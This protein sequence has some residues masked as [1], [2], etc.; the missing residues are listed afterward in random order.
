MP[1]TSRKTYFY[2]VHP[3]KCVK[4]T[5]YEDNG[6]LYLDVEQILPVQDVGD[7][8]IR[9]NAKKQDEFVSQKDEAARH[10]VRREFWEFA[11]PTLREKTGIYNNV[12]PSKN[13]SITGGSG[14]SG[15]SYITVILINGARAELYIDVG[16]KDRNKQIFRYFQEKKDEI[17]TAFGG[18]LLW[19][20]LPDK[21]TSL[22]SVSLEK[23]G[24]YDTDHW[25]DITNFLGENI[26]KLKDAFKSHIDTALKSTDA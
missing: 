17:E 1:S 8:Q 3:I 22:I 23:Y 26:A 9:L 15:I 24:L 4:V 7:Y 16:E 14:Y 18:E 11:L 21:R 20:E 13:N 2:V 12:S 10:K 5:L 19:E 25:R 6:K